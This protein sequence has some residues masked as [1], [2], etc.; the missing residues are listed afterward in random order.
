MVVY[1]SHPWAAEVV[2]CGSQGLADQIAQ[3]NLIG[4][5]HMKS[6]SHLKKQGR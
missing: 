2:A 3:L 1:T 4:K 6:R 5:F